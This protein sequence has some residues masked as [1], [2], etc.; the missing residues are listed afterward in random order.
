L[1]QTG[2]RTTPVFSY[3]VELIDELN[4]IYSLTFH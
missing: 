4:S 2:V 1:S 3:I